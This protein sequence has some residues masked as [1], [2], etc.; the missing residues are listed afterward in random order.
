[1]TDISGSES[2][3]SGD[4]F[5]ASS[6]D[7]KREE[8]LYRHP[9]DAKWAVDQLNPLLDPQ[10]QDIVAQAAGSGRGG[11]V[12][13]DR[14]ASVDK[15]RILR[16]DQQTED[17]TKRWVRCL[18][19]AAAIPMGGRNTRWGNY[20]RKS[21]PWL[22]TALMVTGSALCM[23]GV[24]AAVGGPLLAVGA[25]LGVL[26]RAQ[27]MADLTVQYKQ[28]QEYNRDPSG[29]AYTGKMAWNAACLCVVAVPVAGY[30]A[31]AIPGVVGQ[32]LESTN[33]PLSAIPD[34]LTAGAEIAA[35]PGGAVLS[36]AARGISAARRKRPK[37]A[38][39]VTDI[40]GNFDYFN[41]LTG[42]KENVS[43]A[44]FVRRM[45]PV[46]D[47]RL[48]AEPVFFRH[49]RK[50]PTPEVRYQLARAVRHMRSNKQYSVG[51]C[52]ILDELANDRD[53]GSIPP[54][55]T[56]YDQDC[57]DS[58]GLR[59][60]KERIWAD[61]ER[62]VL[63]EAKAKAPKEK[64]SGAKLS[65]NELRNR[66]HRRY[67][68]SLKET[69]RYATGWVKGADYREYR[70]LGMADEGGSFELGYKEA[71]KLYKL[72]PNEYKYGDPSNEETQIAYD[73]ALVNRSLGNR[74]AL[75][76]DTSGAMAGRDQ[77]MVYHTASGMR[78]V[79]PEEEAAGMGD[80]QEG[81]GKYGHI[82]YSDR[83]DYQDFANQTARFNQIVQENMP[84]CTFAVTGTSQGGGKAAYSCAAN[85]I[86][87]FTTDAQEL[88]SGT[89]RSLNMGLGYRQIWQDKLV[90]I[91]MEGEKLQDG[92]RGKGIA[93]LIS[94]PDF[95][96]LKAPPPRHRPKE[97]SETAIVGALHG[98]A[99]NALQDQI[100]Y[101]RGTG[102]NDKDRYYRVYAGTGERE[103][104]TDPPPK[105]DVSE[106]EL[107]S[108]A[109][110]DEEPELEIDDYMLNLS[111]ELRTS[112]K[113]LEGLQEQRRRGKAKR[114]IFS[115]LFA[116]SSSSTR[117]NRV[118]DSG[119][120]MSVNVISAQLGVLD[121]LANYYIEDESLRGALLNATAFLWESPSN[122]NDNDLI[123]RY[124]ISHFEELAS[125][126]NDRIETGFHPGDADRL[127]QLTN[128]LRQKP[129]RKGEIGGYNGLDARAL[130]NTIS[131]Y[132]D[133]QGHSNIDQFLHNI[134]AEASGGKDAGLAAD[135]L[136]RGLVEEEDNSQH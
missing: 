71:L 48:L 8:E 113:N 105:D 37:S 44:E 39:D 129:R 110:E 116:S 108:A 115:R 96:R 55:A 130:A 100:F 107:D 80:T 65:E 9:A 106:A 51:L 14:A 75:V 7:S 59:A 104:V 111:R 6:S 12:V 98:W 87:T 132:R 76:V 95:Y 35:T 90:S 66:T 43:A 114:G 63:I 136:N 1:M 33:K 16:D 60:L 79:L 5:Y 15:R 20:W 122:N 47:A 19:K 102:E 32:F 3:V 88:H 2:V 50:K 126:V 24:G 124:K 49:P 91:G 89:V 78:G 30:F 22:S 10:Q 128:A 127:N 64:K 25:G 27:R 53:D 36:V 57:R 56:L 54:G 61:A 45:K 83:A 121:H 99:D 74:A 135:R 133:R 11:A 82:G 103:D 17:S 26:N 31:H 94:Y 69:Q 120:E 29:W 134:R 21:S 125:F 81:Y 117:E 28:D 13:S 119:A 58:F 4:S 62:A 101:E 52:G 84:N 67:K 109:A 118:Q 68:S 112:L 38:R 18:Q 72:L 41:P 97:T 34:N 70:D 123:E 40:Q 73:G 86:P 85:N 131:N 92:Q 23:T 93:H 77:T 42:K 46:G